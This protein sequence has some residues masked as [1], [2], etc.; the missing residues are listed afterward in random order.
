MS[1]QPT[2][3][4]SGECFCVIFNTSVIEMICYSRKCS[5]RFQAAQANDKGEFMHEKRTNHGDKAG[6]KHH[7]QQHSGAIGGNGDDRDEFEHEKRTNPS[8]KAGDQYHGQK[9]SG[10]ISGNSD[11]KIASPPA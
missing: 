2:D 9:H 5:A 8:D 11:D 3:G 10:L 4:L 1:P 6:D 7:G